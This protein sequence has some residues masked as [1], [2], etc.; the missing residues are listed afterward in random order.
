MFP[1]HEFN[2]KKESRSML[3]SSVLFVEEKESSFVIRFI[4]NSFERKDAF[5]EFD[6]SSKC[7]LNLWFGCV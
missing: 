7:T 1:I 6:P 4:N 5:G 2:K 3:S